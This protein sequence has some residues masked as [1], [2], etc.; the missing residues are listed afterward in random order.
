MPCIT[1]PFN[2]DA[3]PTLQVAIVPPFLSG[4]PAPVAINTYSALIDT[5][6]SN[7]IISPR[8]AT[9]LGLQSIGRIPIA[10]VGGTVAGKAY[11]FMVGLQDPQS[12]QIHAWWPIYGPGISTNYDVLIGRDILCRGVLVMAAG[13]IIFCW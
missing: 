3:A 9:A 7:T 10:G 8:T 12:G 1:I 11:L 6:T 4:Q 5:G 2:P 13:Q